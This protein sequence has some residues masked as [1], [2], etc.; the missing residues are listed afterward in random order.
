MK[1]FA[2]AVT[3]TLTLFGLAAFLPKP[4]GGQVAA[5][6]AEPKIQWMSITEAFAKNAK[7]PRKILIDV[8]TDWC[9]WCKVMDKNTFKNPQVAEYVS[10][11]YYAVK[12]DAEQ[13]DPI[14]LGQQKFEFVP[15]GQK[16]YHQLAAALMNGQM[17]YPTTV[18]LDEKLQM[19]QPI[20][21]Y[22]DAP[23]FHQIVTFIG[24]DHYK[25]Q[26]FEKFKAET[27]PKQYAGQKQPA[28]K[29]Q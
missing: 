9:G 21:G 20:P 23:A 27:Y 22:M 1:T 2:L 14:T 13:R 12:L 18:F 8:Y 28:T 24:D 17:S 6:R 26:D 11:K 15:Q 4:E 25:K 5:P 19:I 10:R 29:P 7:E 3:L 16:G